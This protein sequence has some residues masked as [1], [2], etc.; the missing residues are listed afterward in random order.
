[1]SDSND[2]T[3][4]A[5]TASLPLPEIVEEE[6]EEAEDT[7]MQ[8]TQNMKSPIDVQTPKFEHQSSIQKVSVD[9]STPATNRTGK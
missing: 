8:L 5:S 3:A 9:P 2:D 6:Q 4:T 7:D 1:M